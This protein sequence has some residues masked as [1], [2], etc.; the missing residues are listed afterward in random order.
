MVYGAINE[1]GEPW[2]TQMGRVLDA[3]HNRQLDYHWLITDMDGVP[4][5]M[6]ACC[7][8]GGYCWLTGENFTKLVREDDGQW[9]WAVASGFAPDIPLSDIL[10]YPQPYANNYEGFWKKPLSI[11]HPLAAVEIVAWDSSCT[12]LL[13]READ[14]VEDFLDFFPHSEDLAAYQAP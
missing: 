8:E 11:Q 6:E 14:L 3:I 9:I 1:R 13:S 12:L 10:Q 2:Y 5:A 4:P 7:Q